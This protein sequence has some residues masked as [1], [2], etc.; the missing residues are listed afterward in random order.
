MTDRKARDFKK[1]NPEQDPG[2]R[3]GNLE[4]EAGS[5][6]AGLN[7]AGLIEPVPTLDSTT[8]EKVIKNDNNSW[9]VLGRDR[10]A[11]IESGYGGLG[12]TGAG[13]IDIVVG[14]MAGTTEGADSSTTVPPN[15]FS[16]A[17]RVYLSTRTDIDTN[18]ALVGNMRSIGRSG[19]GIKAD[20]VR[21]IGREGVKIVTGK[22]QNVEGGGKGGERNAQSGKIEKVAG[23][24][25]IAGNDIDAEPLEPIVKAYA[26]NTVLQTMVDSIRDLNSIVNEL[27]KSQTQIN[28]TLTSHTHEVPQSP[29]GMLKSLPSLDLVTKIPSKESSKM[30]SVHQ[31][32]AKHKNNLKVAL[33]TDFLSPTGKKWFGSRWNKTN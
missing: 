9:I 31:N 2:E 12:N 13:A 1:L 30:S 20:A 16:D 7:N 27:A 25:L 21:L 8:S 18:F 24:H 11:G 29:T 19:I 15:F 22:A 10:P 14:R 33:E 4:N 3:D 28:N 23:I 5:A 6:W 26:L 17:A 32:L